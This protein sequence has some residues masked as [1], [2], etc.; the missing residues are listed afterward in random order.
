M[1]KT[2]YVDSDALTYY[3][4]KSGIK[5]G[6]IVSALGISRQAFHEKRHGRIAFRGSE[7]YVLCDMLK[8]PDAEKPKI[9]CT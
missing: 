1:V 3:I 4:K 6:M 7:I 5:I 9:F 8:I 2:Q